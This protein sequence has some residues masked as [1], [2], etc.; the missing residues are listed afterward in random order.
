VVPVE[1][2]NGVQTADCDPQVLDARRVDRSMS[3]S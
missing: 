2:S 1:A 3:G